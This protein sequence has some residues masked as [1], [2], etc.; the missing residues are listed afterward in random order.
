MRGLTWIYPDR[1][2]CYRCRKYL[3]ITIIDG[4][5]DS[6]ACA[7]RPHPDRAPPETWPRQHFVWV[8]G[9]RR[10][11]AVWDD[12]RQAQRAAKRNN[13]DAYVC[14]FCG[15]WHIGKKRR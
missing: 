13:K 5:Y 11:K 14:D 3:G 4:L 15:C 8:N 7:G 12:Q 6:Y 9:Q 1:K 10:P 2:R